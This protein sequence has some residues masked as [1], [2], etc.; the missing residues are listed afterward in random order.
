MSILKQVERAT[1]NATAEAKRQNANYYNAP[2]QMPS[3]MNKGGIGSMA[4]DAHRMGAVPAATAAPLALDPTFQTAAVG[5]AGIYG[6]GKVLEGIGKK[7]PNFDWRGRPKGKTDSTPAPLSEWDQLQNEIKNS[8]YGGAFDGNGNPISSQYAVQRPGYVGNVQRGYA[9]MVKEG[10]DPGLSNWGQAAYDRSK[11][12]Q[13]YAVDDARRQAMGDAGG[14]MNMLAMQG[15]LESGAAENMLRQG[16]RM[17][18]QARTDLYRQGSMDRM[19]I[20]VSD[21]ARKDEMRTK[22]LSGQ[23]DVGRFDADVNNINVTNALTDR[24]RG[25]QWGRDNLALRGQL[26]GA[27]ATSDAMRAQAAAGNKSG[28]ILDDLGRSVGLGDDLTENLKYGAINP[29]LAIPG[30]RNAGGNAWNK[31]KETVSKWTGGW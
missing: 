24:E 27:K 25:N 20:D 14:N 1:G 9:D 15:G 6:T 26:A 7:L 30:V 16:Q 29:M 2:E 8:K 13:T 21:A 17:G 12:D 23:M 10:T 18:N 31:S 19:G 22:G 4:R 28:G 11:A 3:W 5:A